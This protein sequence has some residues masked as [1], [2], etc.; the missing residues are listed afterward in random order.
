MGILSYKQNKF[1]YGI[2]SSLAN[3]LYQLYLSQEY[4]FHIKKS[5]AT[6]S[7]NLITELSYFSFY[8][9]AML[10]ILTETL[11]KKFELYRSFNIRLILLFLTDCPVSTLENIN[12]VSSD[13]LLFPVISILLIIS[14]DE[15]DENT[16]K[17]KRNDN[18]NILILFIHK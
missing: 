15:K 11:L 7:K 3:K 16:K 9:N 4:H 13:I 6:L 8:L 14:L 17:F 1:I 10:V 12:I 18:R 5:S 2:N